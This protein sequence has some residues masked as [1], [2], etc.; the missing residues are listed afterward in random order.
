MARAQLAP[1]ELLG[2]GTARQQHGTCGK[3]EDD[4]TD[5]HGGGSPRR[6]RIAA[7]PKTVSTKFDPRRRGWQ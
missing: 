1:L 3:G 4:E 7:V 2:A 6:G 5:A